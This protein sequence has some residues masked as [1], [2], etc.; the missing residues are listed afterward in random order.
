MSSTDFQWE[1]FLNRLQF[2]GNSVRN[3]VNVSRR[4]VLGRGRGERV[5][6]F[7]AWDQGRREAHQ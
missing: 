1:C 5:Q 7:W 2:P 4:I 3:T 6:L